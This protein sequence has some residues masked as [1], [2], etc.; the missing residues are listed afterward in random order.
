MT[1]H[2]I[3]AMVSLLRA[4]ATHRPS[5]LGERHVHIDIE[6]ETDPLDE[7]VHRPAEA[8][9]EPCAV[10]GEAIEPAQPGYRLSSAWWLHKWGGRGHTARPEVQS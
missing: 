8:P 7:S 5:W 9:E 1:S 2:D 10:C 4:A 6:D 3:D